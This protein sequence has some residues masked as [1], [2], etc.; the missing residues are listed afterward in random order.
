[1]NLHLNTVL[2]FRAASLRTLLPVLAVVGV[3]ACST[4]P[5]QGVTP[6]SP[7]DV[8]RY[9]GKWYEIAR[10]DH[11]FERGLTNVSATYRPQADG[12]VEVI[13]RGY[14]AEEGKWREAVGRAVFTGS[15]D[16]GSLK[17]SFFG[18]FYG[19]YHVVA[20]DQQD[21]RWAMVMGPDRGYLWILARERQLSPAVRAALLRQ[22]VALGVNTEAVIWVKHER[23]DS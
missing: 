12:S 22:A 16:R 8:E 10:L 14:D 9:K 19:G 11:S 13:N 5:P 15:S 3:A 20:L 1:M 7:F 4:L 18:P 17:V 2:P 21:Y 23:D 6:V